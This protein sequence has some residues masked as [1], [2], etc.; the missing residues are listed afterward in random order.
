MSGFFPGRMNQLSDTR[1]IE[2]LRRVA[3]KG[4]A[5]QRIP[6]AKLT[7]GGANGYIAIDATGKIV[8]S[9]DPT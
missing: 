6:L 4:A 2:N 9:Q 5:V 8:D 3:Y 7:T 1:D